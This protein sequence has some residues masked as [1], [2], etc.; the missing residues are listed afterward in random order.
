MVP[1]VSYRARFEAVGD[2]G[3][4]VIA[5]TRVRARLREVTISELLV[6]PST[7]GVQIARALLSDV[8]RHADADYVAACAASGTSER[9]ALIHAGFLP[10]PYL[11]PSFT[12]RRLSTQI[13]DPTRW[14]NWR[15]S[16][17]DLE[18]F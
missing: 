7:R 2:A 18:L 1:G 6:T 14:F 13:P 8:V 17:G 15:C 11:G 4:L 12:A 5:R 9:R 10:A 16:I 3:A